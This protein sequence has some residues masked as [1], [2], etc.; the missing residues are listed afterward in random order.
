MTPEKTF[1]IF[2]HFIQEIRSNKKCII[3]G[4]D[5][6]VLSRN[7]YDEMIKKL[8]PSEYQTVS[9]DEEVANDWI[10]KLFLKDDRK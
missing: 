7:V 1:N 10:K 8:N 2:M 4:K 3:Y 9:Y 6:V 5:Y